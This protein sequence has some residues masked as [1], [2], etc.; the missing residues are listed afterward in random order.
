M[1]KRDRLTAPN[2]SSKLVSLFQSH[3]GKKQMR[4]VIRLSSTSEGDLLGP[5]DPKRI[6]R[7]QLNEA[8]GLGKVKNYSY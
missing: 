2:E 5:R 3:A 7:A 6:S 1:S 4:F 8:Q